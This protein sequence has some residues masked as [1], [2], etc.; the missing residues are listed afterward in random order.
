MFSKSKIA[1]IFL[2]LF[3][4]SWGA[5]FSEETLDWIGGYSSDDME[6]SQ[7]TDSTEEN[8]MYYQWQIDSLKKAV[9]PRYIRMLE[10]QKYAESGNLLNRGVLFTY[11]GQKNKAVL[12]CGN[13]L[14]W[15]CKPLQ[16]NR[17]GVFYSLIPTDSI[18][19]KY[20]TLRTYEYKFKVDGLYEADPENPEFKPD[21]SGSLVSTFYLERI[22]RDKFAHSKV[23]DDSD[24]EEPHLR[25]VLFSIY[26]PDKETISVTGTFNNWN[27]EA[28]YLKKKPDGSFELKKKLLPGTYHYQ[29]IADGDVVIDLYN[30][31]V[32][33]REPYEE[34]V[35]ELIVQERSYALERK[36]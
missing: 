18:D 15:K 30:P 24:I 28:D 6:D 35:S 26:L 11:S 34:L 3:L 21:G 29:F 7:A 13:F 25:T 19:E 31:N 27:Y 16:K 4:L 5:L 8:K 10:I 12:V 33:V 2:S 17:F 14:N 9:S 23:L 20:E 22:D 36:K 32:K 1:I